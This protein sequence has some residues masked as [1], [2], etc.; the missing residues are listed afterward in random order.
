MNLQP[1]SP[2]QIDALVNTRHA[3]TG[4][5]FPPAGLQPYHQ[6]LMRTLHQLAE[7]SLGALRVAASAEGATTVA[8][9]PGRASI[10]GTVVACAGETLDLASFNN[11]TALIWLGVD[12]SDEA[13][14]EADEDWPAGPH[15]KLAEVELAAGAIASVLDRRME[16]VFR[17]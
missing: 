11:S 16:A 15:L 5:E 12:E 3:A 2:E 1:L 8:V 4:I 10:D 7:C 17:V 13:I 6:W 9:A 14:V